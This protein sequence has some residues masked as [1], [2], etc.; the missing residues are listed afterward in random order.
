MSVCAL[1][2]PLMEDEYLE[3]V[4]R[5]TS[6]EKGSRGC[7]LIARMFAEVVNILT[8]TDD[9]ILGDLY[10]GGISRGEHGQFLTPMAICRMQAQ[11]LLPQEPTGIE[12]RRSVSD[13]CCGSGRMLMAAAEVQPDW[14]FVGQDVDLRCVRL[15]AINLALRNRYGHVV[16]GNTLKNTTR[17]VYETGRLQVYGNV[18]RKVALAT[19]PPEVQRVELQV[20]QPDSFEERPKSQLNLFD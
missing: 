19:T 2:H 4:A 7:D 20:P 18:I 1:G 15:T 9:D 3:T 12:G 5:H 14:H 16:W 11:M 10:Q 8:R 17:M 13:P 6:G